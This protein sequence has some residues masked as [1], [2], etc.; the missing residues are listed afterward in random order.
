MGSPS[1]RVSLQALSQR[2]AGKD[3]AAHEADEE[4]AASAS[5]SAVQEEV[6]S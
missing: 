2:E 1:G 4:V 5:A 6:P 3:E